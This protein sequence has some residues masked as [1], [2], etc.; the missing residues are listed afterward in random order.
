VK[1]TLVAERENLLGLIR[2]YIHSVSSDFGL[3]QNREYAKLLDMPEVISN[4]HWVRQLECK[5]FISILF[6]AEKQTGGVVTLMND[7][8]VMRF[9]MFMAAN[10]KL[11]KIS[12]RLVE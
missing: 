5:V 2:E 10:L 6:L 7:Y 1:N 3:G 12:K 11:V 4:I 8:L 9:V